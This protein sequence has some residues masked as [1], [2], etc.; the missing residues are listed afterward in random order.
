MSA[1]ILHL[2][3]ESG[4]LLWTS[5]VLAQDPTIPAPEPL[6]VPAPG[7]LLWFLLMLTFLLHILAMN[8]VLGGSIIAGVTR[9]RAGAEDRPHHLALFRW[10]S[11]AM[12]VAV[13][14]AITLGV[15]PLLFVQV[16][17]GRLFFASSVLMAWFWIAVIP[18]LTLAYLTAYL[19]AF[20]GEQPGTREL[21]ATWLMA[22]L[23]M[24][25]GFI[26]SNN[27]SLMLRPEA[28]LEI[29]RTDGSGLNLN[30][31]DP[32][33]FPRFLHMLVAAIGVAG[34]MVAVVGFIRRHGQGDFGDWA[35]RYGA[36]WFVGA[37][38]LNL[39][40]GLFFLGTQPRA[41]LMR[42]LGQNLG[43]TALLGFGVLFALGALMM[44]FTSIHAPEPHRL[45]RGTAIALV[46]T[47]VM[48]VL[49]RD[50]VRRAA[51]EAAEFEPAAW[52]EPQWG[53]I[54]LFLALL[55]IALGTVAW[56]VVAIA[57]GVG[58]GSRPQ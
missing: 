46:L 1:S 52:V 31:T 42:F 29:Y 55:V 34:L 8:F 50:Q 57:R 38:S 12:P 41:T 10:L 47:L 5:A 16:L 39:V 26:Y 9:W 58:E 2:F 30:L 18:L 24:V 48:M 3:G 44:A 40:L 7:W 33:L 49:V 6:P 15:A 45:L 14:A 25:I 4:L 20:R 32:V 17:Y 27:M 19:L 23:F 11:K 43:A 51:L 35:M 56:M 22:G 13:A 37:T 53:V 28:F 21:A 54:G 36:R